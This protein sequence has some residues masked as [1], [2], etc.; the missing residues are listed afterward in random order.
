MLNNEN[1]YLILDVLKFH[2]KTPKD[3]DFRGMSI[4]H[5]ML[6]SSSTL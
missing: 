6:S 3:L 4:Y 1:K 2:K 5:P